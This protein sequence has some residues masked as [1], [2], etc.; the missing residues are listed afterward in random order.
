MLIELKQLMY[1]DCTHVDPTSET[2]Y[3]LKIIVYTIAL[4]LKYRVPVLPRVC[5][6]F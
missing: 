4:V 5:I 2:L 3:Q 1:K 6:W